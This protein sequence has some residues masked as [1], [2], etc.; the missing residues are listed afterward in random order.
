MLCSTVFT[1]LHCTRSEDV[2]TDVALLVGLYSATSRRGTSVNTDPV[3]HAGMLT[4]LLVAHQYT[5]AQLTVNS[6]VNMDPVHW[7]TRHVNSS[8][9]S[10]AVLYSV[11]TDPVHQVC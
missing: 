10:W 2:L 7:F 9:A 11:N 5:G 6:A 3:H 4:V 8:N 1:A